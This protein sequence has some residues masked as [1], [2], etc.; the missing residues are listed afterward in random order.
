MQ[1]K[2]ITP[3]ANLQVR[4]EREQSLD[5]AQQTAVGT[6]SGDSKLNDGRRLAWFSLCEAGAKQV[7]FVLTMLRPFTGVNLDPA[8]A[9]QETATLHSRPPLED[10]PLGQAS[11]PDMPRSQSKSG[12]SW[13]TPWLYVILL[14]L[15]GLLLF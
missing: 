4:I 8:T 3:S 7:F 5:R 10:E 9:S 14:I 1:Q 6:Q 2:A 15:V 13:R 12:I 11:C